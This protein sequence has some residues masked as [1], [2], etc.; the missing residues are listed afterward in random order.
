MYECNNKSF[1]I[2]AD[3][4]KKIE[5]QQ[6]KEFIVYYLRKALV[7]VGDVRISEAIEDL[8]DDISDL[9]VSENLPNKIKFYI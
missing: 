4:Q 7:M 5:L 9:T 8:K 3:Q 6:D 1:S 2:T